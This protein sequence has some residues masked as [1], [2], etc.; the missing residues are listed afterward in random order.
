[1]S[2][3]VFTVTHRDQKTQARL[4]IYQTPHG[5]I[6]T[7]AFVAVGTQASVKAIAPD[8]LKTIGT[9][10]IIANTYHLHLRPGEDLIAQMGGLH[11]FMGWNGPMMTDS[12]GFQVFSL[13][14]G[15]EHGVGKIASIFPEE[16]DPGGHLHPAARGESLVKLSEEGVEF[17]SHIDGSKRKFTPESVIEIQ[18]KLGADIILVLDECTSPLHDYEYTRRAMERTHRWAKRALD[19][20]RGKSAQASPQAIY[21]IVQGGAYQDLRFE[22]AKFIANLKFDGIAIGGSLGKSKREM[23]QVLEWT[24]PL[25]PPE[26]PVH[27]LGI[28]TIEDIFEAVERGIDTFDCVAPTRQG[29]TGWLLCRESEDFQL[30]IYNSQHRQDSNPIDPSCDCYTCQHH[31]RAYLQHLFKAREPL[32]MR[33]ATLHNLRFLE[34]LMEE[35]RA[36][37]ANGTLKEL[38]NEWLKA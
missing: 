12:G 20:F 17:R 22:S 5:V 8:D 3:F 6:K 21:G 19:A 29:R 28:G 31:S 36:A 35:I 32:A 38:K 25:L 37:I 16:Q 27:L 13:G 30:N 1:M 10:V 18:R 4:G 34:K 14:A 7:P 23:H 26:K 11:R 15:N 33:L 9:Q 2:E 24:M